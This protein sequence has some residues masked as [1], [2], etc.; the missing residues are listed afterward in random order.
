MRREIGER[1]DREQVDPGRRVRRAVGR[2][3][4]QRRAELL[5]QA[6]QAEVV[7]VH[8]RLGDVGAAPRGDAEGAVDL[9][10]VD[11][12]VDLAAD[13]PRQLGH[14]AAVGQVER[15]QRHL[16]QRRDVVEPRQLLPWL[17]MADPD[18]LGA[19]LHQ[20]LDQRLA[21]LGLAVGDE[22]LAELGVAGHL[23]QHLVVGHVF[24]LLG[25]KSDQHRGAGAVEARADVD[26]HR[27]RACGDATSPCRWTITVGPASSRTRPSRHGS[28]SR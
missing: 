6:Q 8:L 26:A 28:R 20:R 3:A 2:A 21:D 18:D 16:R 9:G 11:D 5:R 12:D 4:L 24:A 19:G 10:V 1:V 22:D 23:A 27:L 15:H 25:R 14:R 13:L 7:D 17:G